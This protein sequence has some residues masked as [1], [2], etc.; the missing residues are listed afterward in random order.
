MQ[1]TIA[2]S[3][4][5]S[6]SIGGGGGGGGGNV[7]QNDQDLEAEWAQSNFVQRHQLS[8]QLTAELPFGEG[9]RWLNNGGV[10]AALLDRWQFQPTSRPFGEPAERARAAAHRGMSHRV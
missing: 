8:L 4:D 1:Y 3:R 9:R 10:G 7:A 5:N 2:K 6:P